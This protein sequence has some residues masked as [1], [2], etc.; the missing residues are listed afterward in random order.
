MRN[1]IIL[2]IP[3]SSIN[4]LHTAQWNNTIALSH[5]V[6]RWTDWHT[7]LFH[8]D[9]SLSHNISLHVFGKSRF[10]VDVERLVDDE[11]ENVG[12]GIVY[13]RFGE[14][15]TRKVS[16]EERQQ[17]M[18][19][20]H[21][22]IRDLSGDIIDT[23]KKNQRPI[24]ID[25]HSFPSDLMD[26]KA[27]DVCIGV[28]DDFASPSRRQLF[29]IIRHFENAGYRVGLNE[30]YSNAIQPIKSNDELQTPY[31]SFM[32]EINKRCY[33]DEPTIT[34]NDGYNKMRHV[35][36]GLYNRILE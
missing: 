26:G 32:I 30:P 24:V 2:N 6:K 25:C 9:P 18:D 14:D 19:E 11:L 34:L 36:L 17:L 23:D 20:Y 35:M 4:A 1:K 10:V 28:N 5:A 16:D 22:Y 8:P 15:L 13:T 12:Q 21:A 3:H 33:I 29:T 7:N 31:Y 27:P